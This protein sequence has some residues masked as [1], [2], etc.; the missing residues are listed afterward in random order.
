MLCMKVTA[1]STL[2]AFNLE[3]HNKGT[4]AGSLY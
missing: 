3:N 4:D 1:A 2:T